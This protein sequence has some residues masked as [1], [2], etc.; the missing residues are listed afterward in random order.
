MDPPTQLLELF[1][2]LSGQGRI[3]GRCWITTLA[4]LLDPATQQL[5]PHAD[6]LHWPRSQPSCSKFI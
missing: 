6:L 5:R 4:F 1:P 3:R 2:L